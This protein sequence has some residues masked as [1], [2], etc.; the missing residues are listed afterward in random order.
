MRCVWDRSGRFYK[1]RGLAKVPG[2]KRCL[3]I[4]YCCVQDVADG[5]DGLVGL[6]VRLPLEDLGGLAVLG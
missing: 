2:D 4:A 3:L 5:H 6:P 1:Q